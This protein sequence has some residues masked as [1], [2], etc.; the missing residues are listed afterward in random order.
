LTWRLID[1]GF[2]GWT[3]KNATFLRK[4]MVTWG[5]PSR[6]INDKIDQKLGVYLSEM[7]G[8]VEDFPFEH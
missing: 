3:I 2:I 8:E 7:Y 5:V 6:K 1:G 4:Y